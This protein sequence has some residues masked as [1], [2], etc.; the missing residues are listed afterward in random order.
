MATGIKDYSSDPTIS[1]FGAPSE[2]FAPNPSPMSGMRPDLQYQEYSPYSLDPTINAFDPLAHIGEAMGGPEEKMAQRPQ[3]NP[4]VGKL[5][6]QMFKLRQGAQATG[7]SAL[8]L[9]LSLPAQIGGGLTYGAARLGATPERA[10]Q[11]SEYV[12]EPLSYLQPGKLANLANKPIG[13]GSE[14]YELSPVSQVMELVSKYGAQPAMDMLISRGMSPE[15]AHHLVAN[16]PLLAGMGFKLG[17]MGVQTARNLPA[18]AQELKVPE[19]GRIEPQMD[20]SQMPQSIGA[21]QTTPAAVLRGNIDAAIANASPELQAHI[22]SKPLESINVPAVETR[23]LEEKHGVDLTAGQR[24]GDLNRYVD[25][26]NARGKT[27]TL[28]NHFANQPKQLADA[29]ENAKIKHAPDISATADASELGQHEINGLAAKDKI[30]TDNIDN[31]YQA[32]KDKWQELRGT[33]GTDDF[34]VDG[35]K[36]LQNTQ[37]ALK[38]ELLHH[39]VPESIS[40]ILDELKENNG[41]MGF[42]QFLKLNQKLGQKMKEGTGSERAAAFVIRQELQKIPMVDEAAVLKP[43]ADTAISLA[44]ERFDV[45]KTNP[46]YKAAIKEALD[47]KDAASDE[48]LNAANFHKKYVSTAT[49]EAIRR[50]KAEIPEND[51]AHQAMTFAELDRAKNQQINANSSNVKSDRFADFLLKESPRLKAALPPEAMQDVSELGLLSSKIG[52]PQ[53]GVFNHSNSFSAYLKELAAQGLATAAEAKLASATAGASVP[54][55]MAGKQWMLS[56]GHENFAK[57]A[58]HPYSGLTKE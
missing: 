29:F 32:L 19:A 30:R 25:E 44:K 55:T 22:Q 45:I 58:I 23:A 10:Q 4:Y 28:S 11:I 56:R 37:T 13:Q 20:V 18:W 52:K 36:F 14:S 50:M 24:T 26:W 47:A 31:A 21:A 51:I 7:L 43:I 15:S 16:A 54:F 5:L 39:D 53:A 49:P 33:T 9:P 3:G 40:K 34:P 27:D 6:E 57:Q 48:S 17:K 38:D 42:S 8:D 46:A 35:K 41:E 12:S 2:D 1:A